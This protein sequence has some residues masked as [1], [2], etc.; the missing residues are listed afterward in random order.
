MI[1]QY[2]RPSDIDRE[3]W[4][5]YDKAKYWFN[6]KMSPAK[7]R[8]KVYDEAWDVE[9]ARKDYSFSEPVYYTSPKTGNRWIT[10][11]TTKKVDGVMH[12]F[13]RI[14]LYYMTEAYMTLMLPITTIDTDDETGEEKGEYHGVNIYT[15]HMFQR[16]HERLGVD[17]T[18][19][20]RAMRNFA[21]FV[22]TGWSDTRP[23]RNGERH[24]QIML[25]LPASWLRGHTIRVGPH[26]VTI[27]RTFYTD[28]SMNP[29]QRRDV[30]TFSRFADEKMKQEKAK[31]EPDNEE[32]KD[33]EKIAKELT[34]QIINN[35]GI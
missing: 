23:P 4:A 29:Q 27:Y 30:R 17:M 25:R 13:T 10:W 31:P 20:I 3:F 14:G 5:D 11:I 26:H 8:Y 6:K 19:R 15:A 18:D 22:G 33:G 21:E 28:R 12:F 7:Q 2:S 9:M 32:N 1:S 16:M 35:N 24:T 34:K